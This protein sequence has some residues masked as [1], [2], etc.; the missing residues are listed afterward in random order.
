MNPAAEKISKNVWQAVSGW[1]AKV[2][3]AFGICL[4]L[5]FTG[6][7]E[8][9][10]PKPESFVGETAPPRKQEFR[11]SNGK[12]PKSFDPALASASPETDFVRAI[13]EGLT[14]IDSKTLQPVPAVAVKWSASPDFKT[15]TFQL[16]Q[17]AK[18]S[19]GEPVT[20]QDFVKSW[21]RLTELGDKVTQRDML[22]NIVGMDTKNVLPIFASEEIDKFAKNTE[23][24]I[25]PADR[26]KQVA[27]NSDDEI[28]PAPKSEIAPKPKE[29]PSPEIT[30]NIAK[31]TVPTVET[32]FGVEAVGSYT[33]KVTLVQPD[34]DFPSLAA[35]P[36]FRPVY[37]NG[38]GLDNLNSEI[39]TNGAFR[40]VEIGTDGIAL[41]RSA[42]Y[43][44]KNEVKLER[45]RFVPTENAETALAA[46]RA[47]DVDAITN[48][49]LQ[50]LALKLL[51]PYD[52]FRRVKHSALNF[53][54]FNL[55]QKVYTDRRVREA[56][57]IAI[58][59]ERLTE[60]EMDGATEPAL[61]FSPF[62]TDDKINQDA[63]AARKLLAEAGFENGENFPKVR[64]LINR[65]NMQ[66]RIAHSIAAMWR[67]NLNIDT[68]II[69]REQA[70]FE[71]AAQ[72]GD[73]DVVRRGI[74]LPTADETANMLAMFPA[75]NPQFNSKLDESANLP[76]DKQIL[77]DKTAE[78]PLDFSSAEKPAESTNAPA[79]TRIP[80]QDNAERIIILTD[81]QALDYLPGIPLYFP[82]SY[83]L[84]KPY[85]QGFEMNELDAPSLKNVQIDSNWQP[86]AAQ[87]ISNN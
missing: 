67:K 61:S 12:T 3:T 83:S 28:A 4:L 33:L 16:R 52:D 29:T 75:K 60:G 86:T 69:V 56:L 79:A 50:P 44:N 22:K 35:H 5:L 73:F 49:D 46:Y 37:G 77:N 54:E 7:N 18:W 82:T 63:G 17:D 21:K 72:I 38:R 45:V 13:Y 87:A 2:F 47:G 48:A 84:V 62:E 78:S 74:V 6:C 27:K 30:A 42:N 8:I 36:I 57:T 1:S 23:A 34:K 43:W 66:Q 51:T 80:S 68:E 14:D 58:E 20:A 65:N 32:K 55:N 31:P 24:E 10:S 64:L 9:K 15:W 25:A 40:I 26:N 70:D 71:T 19:N 76:A 53:Y 81:E 41:E 11:W 59:R 85:V 39:I